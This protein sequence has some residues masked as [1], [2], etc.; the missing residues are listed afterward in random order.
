MQWAN[1]LKLC[2]L[3][4]VDFR[5]KL[6]GKIPDQSTVAYSDFLRGVGWGRYP[7][8]TGGF[9]KNVLSHSIEHLPLCIWFIFFYL[10]LN[11]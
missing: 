11:F 3:Y 4:G 1:I 5:L 6:S 2:P 9:V 7:L 10:I 8:W